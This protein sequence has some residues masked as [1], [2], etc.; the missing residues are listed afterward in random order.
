[1]G[2][3]LALSVSKLILPRLSMQGFSG[4]EP[5]GPSGKH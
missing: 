1:M 2:K 5:G 3:V 4:L